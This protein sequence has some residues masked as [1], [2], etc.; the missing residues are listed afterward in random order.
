MSEEVKMPQMGESIAEGTI[1]RWL[2]KVGDSVKRD[3]PLF[4]IS[5]DKVDAEIPA[6]ASGV[7]SEI[8]V[9]EGETVAV[10]TVVAVING[11]G[12]QPAATEAPAEAAAQPAEQPAQAAPTGTQP[13]DQVTKEALAPDSPPAEVT[14]QPAAQNAAPA[15]PAAGESAPRESA[16]RESA[17]GDSGEDLRRTRSSPLVRKIAKEHGIDISQLEGTGISGRVTKNDILSFIENRGVAEKAAVDKAGAEKAPA[18]PAAAAAPTTR[19][20]Q[21][22]RAPAPAEA[23]VGP[24]PFAE[25]DR[26]E[27]EPMTMMRRRIA[28]R[29]VESRRISAHVTSFMEVDFTE[30]ARLRDELKGEYLKRDGVKLTFMPFIIKAVIDGIKKW[31]IINSSVWGDQIIYKKDINVGVAVALDW[32]L[33]VPVI[34]NADEKSLL[35]L[36][37]AVNDLGDRARSKQLKPDEVQG[38][39]FTITNPGVFGGLT[40]TPII[41]QPQVAILGIGVIKK[42]PVVID[43]AIAIRQ[44]GVLGLSFD[45]RVID[46]AVADQFMAAVRDVIEEAEYTS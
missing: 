34:R 6:P 25:G 1:V 23:E 28:E 7:L 37:R 10:N 5:T 27:I 39:T 26:Y 43:D 9:N 35:G 15:A 21:P 33:I 36:A 30:T 16:P 20:P 42:R 32:G 3:E 2:K 46:G 8:K 24:P 12:A 11:A 22:L 29:M 40:G 4:E 14:E 41:N 18:Q 17:A 31:P 45:H 44:I 19:A 38:G 13:T